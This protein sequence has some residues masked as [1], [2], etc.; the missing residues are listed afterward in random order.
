[1]IIKQLIQCQEIR[2]IL[3]H[4]IK[5]GTKVNELPSVKIE[6]KTNNLSLECQNFKRP[7]K[8]GWGGTRCTVYDTKPPVNTSSTVALL[9]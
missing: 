7:I 1:M 6:N 8:Y 5:Y 3:S 2:K 9:W 4:G